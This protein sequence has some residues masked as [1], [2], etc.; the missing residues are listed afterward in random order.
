MLMK[1][2]NESFKGISEILGIKSPESFFMLN[3]G[4]FCILGILKE[5]ESKG[6]VQNLCS[7]F[8]GEKM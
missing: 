6:H 3:R 8:H 1:K 4:F 5:D 2:K 7:P